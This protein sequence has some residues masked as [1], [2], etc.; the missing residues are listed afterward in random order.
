M[1]NLANRPPLGLKKPKKK[2]N[3]K[4]LAEIHQMN[5]VICTQYSMVQLSATQAH[6]PIHDRFSGA[7]VSD[8]LAIALCEG[9]HQGFFDTSKIAIHRQPKVWRDKYGSD[10]SYSQ[11]IET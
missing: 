8:D 7:K 2:P 3:K 10:Y 4:W 11:K 5:C 1:T 9:H 6:H